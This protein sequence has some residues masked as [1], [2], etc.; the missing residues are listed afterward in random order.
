MSL[1]RRLRPCSGRWRASLAAATMVAII[2]T[3][4]CT[5]AASRSTLV[6]IRSSEGVR[7][8]SAEAVDTYG[9]Q[10]SALVCSADGGRLTPRRC[11]C[12]AAR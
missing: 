7:W 6:E 1:L 11:A 8:V 2:V 12:P 4:G 5:T 10:S 9:C 3:G